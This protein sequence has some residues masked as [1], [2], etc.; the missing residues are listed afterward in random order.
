MKHHNVIGFKK[1]FKSRQFKS[2]LAV[3]TN[4]LRFQLRYMV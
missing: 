1:Q 3:T 4:F 2:N